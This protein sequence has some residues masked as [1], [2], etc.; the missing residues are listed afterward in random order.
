V[1]TRKDGSSMKI[2]AGS[3]AL[4]GMRSVVEAHLHAAGFITIGS[5]STAPRP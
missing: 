3:T 5:P 4:G 2:M 1:G